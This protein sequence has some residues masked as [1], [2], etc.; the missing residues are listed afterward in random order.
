MF[1]NKKILL[2]CKETFT[3]PL[4]FAARKWRGSNTVASFFINPLETVYH[5]SMINKNT[6]YQF[7]KL[8]NVKIFD[9]ND[10]TEIFTKNIQSPPIDKEFIENVE[11]KYTHYKNLNLQLLSSQINTTYY[12]YRSYFNKITYEQQLY[13]LELNYKKVI[14]V[15]NIFKPDI[16]IDT[17]N[18]E[19]PRTIISEIAFANDT[20]YV[21]IGYPRYELFKI[22]SYNLSIGIDR[23][24]K[25]EYNKFKK[26]ALTDLK[27]EILYVK[28]FRD[29]KDIMSREYANDITSRYKKEK[30]TTIFKRLIGRFYYLWDQDILSRN[31][32]I[33]LRNQVLFHQSPKL[34]RFFL[35]YEIKRWYLSRGNKIFDKPV[36]GEKYVYMPLHLIP[37]SSTLT[38]APFYINEITI[39]EQV[40]KSLPAGWSL[41]VKEHQS[42][43]G[44]RAIKFYKQIKKLSNVKIVQ[45][46][47]YDDPK[48]WIEHSE[49]VV[50]VSGTSAYEAAML[51]KKAIVFGDVPFS[52]I[53]GVTRVHSFEDLPKLI[54]SFGTID[55]IKSC[56]SYLATV[57][58]IGMKINLKYL[59]AEGEAI[60]KGDKGLS[61]EFQEQID[62]LMEFYE[63][64][65][66]IYRDKTFKN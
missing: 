33:K 6:Y 65:Y 61:N 8:D 48:P 62:Q 7:L 13:W 4:F 49:G 51:G 36:I 54:A 53:D 11:K 21:S 16:I 57:K 64:A 59:M 17:D 50:S 2:I 12:H 22:P 56:A 5:K 35:I 52:H 47:Y 14:E 55:N 58:S 66:D 18:S 43:V 44:E 25:V 3:Y 63:K 9:T 32:L 34:I 26:S 45:Y 20:P 19:L 37:E 38:L 60:I 41:Y 23:I 15:F 27:E 40:S 31:L 29:N 30:L 39:I 1:K 42:M 46:N 24:F 28:S 10:I